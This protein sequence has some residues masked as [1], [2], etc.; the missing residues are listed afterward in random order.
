MSNRQA[1]REQSR[2]ARTQR[3]TRPSR[4][5]G[6][7]LSPRKRGGGFN[8]FAQPFLLVVAGL[9]IVLAVILGIV[10]AT[11][12]SSNADLVQDLEKAAN[13]LPLDLANGNKLGRDD[14]PIKL[15]EYEDFQCPFCLR[16]SATQ[17]PTLIN[18]YVKTGKV[19]IIYKNLPALGNE[20]VRAGIAATCAADQNKFW[21]YHNRLFLEQARAGQ[22]TNEQKNVG[23]FSDDKLKSYAQE[24]GLDI[25]KYTACFND[26]ATLNKV[27]AE[28]Q[29]A[30]ALNFSSTPSF[31]ANGR[32]LSQ[33]SFNTL[34]DW[35]KALDTL[36]SA[37]P[38]PQ[39][40]ATASASGTASPAAT[41]PAASATATPTK[42]Q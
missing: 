13:D 7:G 39:P 22:A 2:T 12:G 36:L 31:A 40:S 17:E 3:P 9:I 21:Q 30:S 10:V 41:T 23:R 33:G 26:P 32:P 16:Y 8:I 11:G 28:F 18:E 29:E 42:A 38:T 34:D 15:A 25:D 19:Q 20:S 6:G 24:V 4:P 35:R 1:R 5:G 37:T 14:A 27:Q